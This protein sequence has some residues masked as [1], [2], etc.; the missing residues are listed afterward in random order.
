MRVLPGTLQCSRDVAQHVLGSKH[1][2]LCRRVYK[3]QL[4]LYKGQLTE[5]G[6]L[7]VVTSCCTHQA[8]SC[9]YTNSINLHETKQETY[10]QK[11]SGPGCYAPA[12][13]NKGFGLG[14]FS[15]LSLSWLGP[16]SCCLNSC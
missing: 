6:L 14:T 9:N 4:R 15:L 11:S 16:L 5:D 12:V 7:F 3:H 8:G 2:M 13:S 1:A 10:E